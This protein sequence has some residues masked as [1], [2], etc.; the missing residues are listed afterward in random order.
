VADCATSGRCRLPWSLQD[1]G[2]NR[3]AGPLANSINSLFRKD[4][5]DVALDSL[6]NRVSD[7]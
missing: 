7:D 4:I 5:E 2:G 1:A 6:W 3:R